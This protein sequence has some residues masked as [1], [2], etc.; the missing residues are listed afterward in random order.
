MH[1]FHQRCHI[2]LKITYFKHFF[3]MQVGTFSASSGLDIQ[4]LPD[5][6]PFH[7]HALLLNPWATNKLL[8]QQ[9]YFSLQFCL[10][11]SWYHLSGSTFSD[12]WA[13]VKHLCLAP[14]RWGGEG[15]RNWGVTKVLER[16]RVN[17]QVL[18]VILLFFMPIEGQWHFSGF[19]WW[20]RT[21][22]DSKQRKMLL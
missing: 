2:F 21:A 12:T 15:R 19:S 18:P 14:G 13:R 17:S 8:C 6:L 7:V 4:F 16:K 22:E 9:P 10:S 20:L 11:L 5:F 1:I 3:S